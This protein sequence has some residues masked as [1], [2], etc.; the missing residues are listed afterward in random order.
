PCKQLAYPRDYD[1]DA[2]RS[3]AASLRERLELVT[4]ISD[5]EV[6]AVRHLGTVDLDGSFIPNIACLLL[7][8]KEPDKVIPGCKVRF[9]RFD[10]EREGA[11][12][13]FNAVKDIWIEGLTIP[14]MIY[15]AEQILD[16]HIRTFAPLEKDKKFHASPE[17]PK[18]AWYEA[19]VNACVHRS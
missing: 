14:Q 10:G 1:R 5:E 18:A 17:Y 16:T 13:K 15:K 8:P 6:L 9:L 12:E 7:F 4:Q 3:F 2:I 19:I 11:G